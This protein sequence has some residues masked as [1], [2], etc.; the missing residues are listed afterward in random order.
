[1]RSFLRTCLITTACVLSASSLANAQSVSSEPPPAWDPNYEPERLSDGTPS[2]AGV[3]SKA[4]LT[5]L[6]RPDLFEELVIPPR[7]ARILEMRNQQATADANRPTDPDAGGLESGGGVEAYNNFWMDPGAHYAIIDG[8]FRSSFITDPENGQVPYSENGRKIIA[9]SRLGRG[10]ADHPEER[11]SGERCTVGFGS[12]GGPP[13]LNVLYNNHIQFF[14]APD[15][16]IISILVE[17]NHNARMIRMNAEH[18]DEAL[19]PW[20]GD[21]IGYWDG[22]TLVV[23]T[24]NFHPDVSQRSSQAQRFY[25]QP[26]THV[27]ER[28][29]RVADD[30]IFYEYTVTDPD[31]FTQ[32]WK[33]EMPIRRAEGPIYEYACHEG[34][35]SLPGILAGARREEADAAAA[36]AAGSA[37]SGS[38]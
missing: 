24:T 2:F 11:S 26:D 37:S 32:P 36:D 5:T 17:M 28:F 12:T 6:E 4:S 33:A 14:Q 13:M 19:D 35:H 7:P 20:L 8:E 23:E 3:W 22:D 16:D 15:S 9:Q 10:R 25:L 30:T 27:E 21:S 18:R 1:M 29:T 31:L 34:N 38:H